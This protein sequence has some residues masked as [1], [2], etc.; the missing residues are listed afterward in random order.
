MA[1]ILDHLPFFVSGESWSA[2]VG[3]R[4]CFRM[5]CV[6]VCFVVVFSTVEA[7][8]YFLKMAFHDDDDTG[9]DYCTRCSESVRDDHVIPSDMSFVCVVLGQHNKQQNKPSVNNRRRMIFQHNFLLHTDHGRS[10]PSG[11]GGGI[12]FFP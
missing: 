7:R 2:S 10:G 6:A 8:K 9:C 5:G 3:G 4:W 12:F 1:T 11:K